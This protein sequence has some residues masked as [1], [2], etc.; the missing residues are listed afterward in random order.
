MLLATVWQEVSSKTDNGCLK[1][2]VRSAVLFGGEEWCQ[3]ENE[4]GI[5]RTMRS[6]V[7]AMC[8]VQLKDSKRAK[9]WM[10]MLGY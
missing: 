1:S 2:Y 10:L 5:L 9:D 3:G 7:R 8:G 4:M 6:M